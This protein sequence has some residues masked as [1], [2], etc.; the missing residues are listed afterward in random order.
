M[1]T[2]DTKAE[3]V[4]Q[5]VQKHWGLELPKIIISVH[6]GIASF[7][8]PPKLKRNFRKGVAKFAKTTGAWLMTNG[9]RAGIAKHQEAAL[10]CLV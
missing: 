5:L 9:I 10:F 1:A 7:D 8:L 3:S 6:G 4:S 2:I